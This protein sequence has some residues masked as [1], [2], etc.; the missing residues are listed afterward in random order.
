MICPRPAGIHSRSAICDN[1]IV[2]DLDAADLRIDGDDGGMGRVGEHPGVMRLVARSRGQAATSM[3][4]GRSSGWWYQAR[5]ISA[6]S[7][8]PRGP[9]RGLRGSPRRHPCI[10]EMSADAAIGP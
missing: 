10:A 4:A 6:N 7:T 5:P 9:S 3:S 8:L 2:E 1:G